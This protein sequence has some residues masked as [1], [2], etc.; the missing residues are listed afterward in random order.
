MTFTGQAKMGLGK[1]CVI[2]VVV[3]IGT[4]ALSASKSAESSTVEKPG[5]VSKQVE[6][7][8]ARSDALSALRKEHS[9]RYLTSLSDDELA[10]LYART[11]AQRVLPFDTAL[12]AVRKDRPNIIEQ[13][14]KY[15]SPLDE[16]QDKYF[17][18]RDARLVDELAA[19]GPRALPVITLRMGDDYRRT[20]HS[21]LAVEALLKMGPRAVELLI[22]L[23]D[24]SD[25][26]LRSNV[27]YVLSGLADPR[28]KDAL[29]QALEDNDGSVRRNAISGLVRLGPDVVGPSKLVAL[30]INQLQDG[31]CLHE[32]IQGLE[33][34]GDES[35][36]EPLRV[37]ERFYVLRG[38]ADLRYPARMA[39]NAI[40]QR[41]G[42]PVTE[43]SREHYSH[44]QPSYD[45]IRQATE[46]PNAAIR[47]HAVLLLDRYRDDRTALFLI[48]RISQEKNP[49]VLDQIART[50][51]ILISQPKG[52]LEPIVSP[53]VMQKA[54]DAFLFPTETIPALS[55]KYVNVRNPSDFLPPQQR[56]LLAAV[57]NGAGGVLY[58]ANERKVR[59]ERIEG[60]KNLVW[61]WGLTS[62]DPSLRVVSYSAVTTIATVSRQTGQ[63]WL[64]YQKE[65]LLQ[66]L[67][68]LLDS[69]NPNIR[70][71]ECLGHIGDRRLTVRLIE[72]LEHS[73]PSIRTFAAY[74]LG[75]IGDSQALPA[76]KHLAETD[77]YQYEN[78]VYGV[79]EAARRAIEQ[80]NKV[81]PA[82]LKREIITNQNSG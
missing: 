20:G 25:G 24:S 82:D 60:F 80:I 34:Y 66:E 42:K 69:P 55:T 23:M 5:I 46:C 68:P 6:E 52:S 50:L 71:I 32:S 48:E 29:L 47:Q 36:I 65:Q 56:K 64:Q 49:G 77:P 3:C 14:L 74:A 12:Q 57:I 19:L 31:T 75:Q 38:K 26:Y 58:A 59:L 1:R 45:E 18:S 2:L 63:S 9:R 22:P 35:A 41:V 70:L 67:A 37:I 43:V 39:M 8:F 4:F 44:E 7:I 62:N 30:L 16:Q 10:R 27:S 81:E 28:A 76:L 51:S 17:R 11:A 61:I 54:F 21:A 79:R 73:D 53:E 78:G 40:L 33:Q 13:F 72:L 15:R